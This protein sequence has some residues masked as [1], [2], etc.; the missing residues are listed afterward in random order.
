MNYKEAS[1]SIYYSAT[2]L[3][4][5]LYIVQ[6]QQGIASTFMI[7][8]VCFTTFLLKKAIKH[9]FCTQLLHKV[10]QIPA[11]S[12]NLI[13]L[14]YFVQHQHV[15]TSTGYDPNKTLL[16]HMWITQLYIHAL[17]TFIPTVH[18]L[19]RICCYI[20][21]ITARSHKKEHAGQLPYA[22][23]SLLRAAQY[24]FRNLN[25]IDFIMLGERTVHLHLHRYLLTVLLEAH[26]H[27]H[28][29]LSRQIS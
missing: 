1:Q 17:S 20:K 2:P 22:L 29:R 19:S 23:F 10:Q 12:S 24:L 14:L 15:H 25:L 18:S 11:P 13:E 28:S 16:I 3:L 6:L 26:G 9:L 21:S 5:M 8:V 4:L 27:I 7:N